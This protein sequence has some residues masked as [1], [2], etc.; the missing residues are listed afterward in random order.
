MIPNYF[1]GTVREGE[2]WS[3][4]SRAV[5]IYGKLHVPASFDSYE[6]KVWENGVAADVLVAMTS[7]P[8][9]AVLS[10]VL[11][12]PWRQDS[13]GYNLSYLVTRDLF[14]AKGGAGYHIELALIGSSDL[15]TVVWLGDVSIVPTRR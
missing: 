1:K 15:G 14:D 7:G 4:Q 3:I 11:R 8:P 2:N 10:S 13:I 9:S 6:L 12:K 5:D